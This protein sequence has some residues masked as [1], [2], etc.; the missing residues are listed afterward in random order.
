MT[1]NVLFNGH[2]VCSV[3]LHDDKTTK[4]FYFTPTLH[5]PFFQWMAFTSLGVVLVSTM[6]FVLGTFPGMNRCSD[7]NPD[8][9]AN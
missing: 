1:E 8:P 2:N 7:A 4:A 9:H 6:T 3:V 5:L